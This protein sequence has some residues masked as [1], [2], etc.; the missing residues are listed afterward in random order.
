M[1]RLEVREGYYVQFDKDG[2]LQGVRIDRVEGGP[3]TSECP[4]KEALIV[5]EDDPDELRFQ[6]SATLGCQHPGKTKETGDTDG[7]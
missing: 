5:G 1:M 6:K 2:A 3:C 7:T 4:V